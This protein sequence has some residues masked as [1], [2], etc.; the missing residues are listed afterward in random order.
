MIVIESPGSRVR[1]RQV[2]ND[3][4]A[5]ILKLLNEPSFIENIG[6][7][8]VRT[9]EDTGAY[10]DKVA[11]VTHTIAGL[12]SWLVERKSDSIPMGI[13][14]LLKRSTLDDIDLGYA[15]VPE[16][17]GVGYAEESCKALMAYARIR[18][19][20]QRLVAVTS[21][22]NTA[23]TRLLDKLGFTFERYTRLAG[24]REEL[25]LHAIALKV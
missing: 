7:R 11:S 14:T 8:G 10:L 1:L 22:Q 25:Q 6:D 23:S 20:L 16:Y 17:W 21:A 24:G 5:F 19:G 15:L 3:D 2:G 18:L 4:A 13:C 12:G 9:L